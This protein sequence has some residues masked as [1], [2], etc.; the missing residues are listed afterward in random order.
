MI[1]K[2]FYLNDMTYEFKNENIY[3]TKNHQLV[4]INVN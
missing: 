3:D 1:F 2:Q 4:Q